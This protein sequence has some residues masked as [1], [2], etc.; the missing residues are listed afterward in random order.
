MYRPAAMA[1]LTSAFYLLEPATESV[2]GVAKKNIPKIIIYK[3]V[4]S[5]AMAVRSR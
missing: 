3:N 5:R 1:Q 2:N 4:R